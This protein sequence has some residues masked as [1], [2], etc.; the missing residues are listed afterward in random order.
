M[1]VRQHSH[2]YGLWQT[3]LAYKFG[4]PHRRIAGPTSWSPGKLPR[5]NLI[6][7]PVL[8]KPLTCRFI[9]FLGIHMRNNMSS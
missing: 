4:P 5:A 1:R 2:R 7:K 8:C 3:A 9:L 6:L